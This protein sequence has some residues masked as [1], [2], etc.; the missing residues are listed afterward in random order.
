[1][2]TALVVAWF[3]LLVGSIVLVGQSLTLAPVPPRPPMNL[4]LPLALVACTANDAPTD[5]DPCMSA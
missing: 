1:M 4:H 5:L 3:G 2:L